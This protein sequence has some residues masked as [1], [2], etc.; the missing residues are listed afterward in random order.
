MGDRKLSRRQFVQSSIAGGIAA[1]MTWTSHLPNAGASGS[2][3]APGGVTL[4]AKGNPQQGYGVTILLN[5]QPLAHCNGGGEFTALFQNGERSLEDRMQNW[6]ATAYTGTPTH[7]TLSGECRLPNLNSTVFAEVDYEVITPH[8]VRKRIRIHQ[9]D[10][11][12]LFYNVSHDLDPETPPAKFWSFNQTDCRG[13]ALHEFYPAA[14]FRTTQGV[15]VG[16]LTDAGFRNHWSRLIRRDGKPVKPAPQRIPDV[17][18]NYIPRPEER[19]KGQRFVRQTFGQALVW[20][21]RDVGEAVPL[22]PVMSWKRQGRANLEAR[23]GVTV[24]T[25]RSS[26]D[27]VVVPFPAHDG[28]VYSVRLRYRSPHPF[29]VEFWDVDDQLRKLEDLT[30]YNDRIPES[31]TDWA[32]FETIVFFYS[33]RGH[34]GA[35][36]ISMPPSEQAINLEGPSG[37]APIELRDLELRRLKTRYQPYHRLEM[38]RPDE[39]TSFIFVDEH[40][41]DTLRGYRLASQ[42]HLADALGFRGGETEKVLY[43]DLM[44]LSWIAGP[45]YFQPMVAP[46]I[47]YSAAGE[48]YLRDSFFA[49]NGVYDR[50]LNEGV[51]NLW[52]ANQGADGAI[53]TLVEP[54][55]ANLERKSNDST[56]LWLIWALRNRRRFGTDLPTDKL[57]KAAEYCLKTY[58]RNHDGI[59]WAQFVMGQLDVIDFPEGR[60]DVCENQG[61]LAVTLRVIK[62]LGIPGVSEGISEDYFARVEEGYRSYYDPALK[63]LRPGR[64]IDNAV[65]FDEI[66]PEFISLWLF[67]HKILTDE[68]M[69]NHLDCIPVLLPREDAPYPEAGGTARPIFIGLTQSGRGW[70]YF[71][72]TWHPMISREHGANYANH[73]MDGIYYNGGSWMRIE[74]CGYVAG[75]LHGWI[76]ADKAIANR[77]WAE[78]HIAADFPT[79]QEYLATDPA[80]PFFGY[81][82]VFAWNAFVLQAL[83]LA[84]LRQ[85]AMDPDFSRSLMRR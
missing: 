83:E 22:P 8:V 30:L 17:N 14:G 19:A 9:L 46:S 58:D 72:D 2:A 76:K 23:E 11:Y 26:E 60:T 7:L 5:G 20:S 33:R 59:C 69:C 73:Q 61:M 63:H 49:A 77:L 48:M 37:A 27:G 47:W 10:M 65:G 21:D 39:K 79:S 45:E 15:T 74:I 82:R 3:P 25:A 38:D 50:A 34:G 52:A 43:A 81:H 29:A 56:P 4:E 57:R 36:L 80:H 18:L 68:M 1:G 71:T 67:N 42:L 78:L 35:L 28:E 66:F 44:M 13:G 31:P 53:N 70:T 64:H 32:E 54:N 16:L 12:A 55:M 6:K 75:K 85:P 24:L 40:T 62:E 51:F 84:G 41:P